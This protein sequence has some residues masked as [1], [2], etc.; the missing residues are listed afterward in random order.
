[1]DGVWACVE[2]IL[3]CLDPARSAGRGE[4]GDG[5][6]DTPT[7]A[8]PPDTDKGKE[9]AGIGG[10]VTSTHPTPLP[11]LESFDF[12]IDFTEPYTLVSYRDGPHSTDVA[13]FLRSLSLLPSLGT[14]S[15][16][17]IRR[18]PNSYLNMLGPSQV[19]DRLGEVVEGWVGLVSSIHIPS[20]YHSCEHEV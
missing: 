11:R 18:A 9:P 12:S 19:L 15:R 3:G 20:A 14:V 17:T 4:G 1:M 2:G 8:S 13:S 5:D 10:T 7:D 16:L 6:A